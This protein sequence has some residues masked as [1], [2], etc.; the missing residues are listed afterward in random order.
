MCDNFDM[1]IREHPRCGVNRISRTLF[2]DD[3]T[4]II[5]QAEETIEGLDLL[6]EGED[7]HNSQ[8]YIE[9]IE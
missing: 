4:S 2:M 8:F 3:L 5:D 9:K 1:L 7:Y 6:K